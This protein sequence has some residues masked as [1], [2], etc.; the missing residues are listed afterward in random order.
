MLCQTVRVEL[1]DSSRI[2]LEI[3]GPYMRGLCYGVSWPL[4]SW[5]GE[6]N[7]TGQHA[8]G[9]QFVSADGQPQV[10]GVRQLADSVFL[11]LQ[12][13]INLRPHQSKT[14][15]L[16]KSSRSSTQSKNRCNG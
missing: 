9:G 3:F 1:K 11:V 6:A 15:R 10:V 13:P 5:I 16:A 12:L 2:S 8:V 4:A 7:L 14:Q